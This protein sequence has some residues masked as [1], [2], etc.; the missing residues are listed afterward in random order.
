MSQDENDRVLNGTLPTDPFADLEPVGGSDDDA[1]PEN[2]TEYSVD[3]DGGLVWWKPT[4]DGAVPVKLA[5]FSAT[6][7]AEVVEDD[8]AEER[9]S[10]DLAANVRGRRR[11][12]RV[13]GSQFA[14]MAWVVEEL[15][16]GAILEPGPGVKDRVRHAVQAL[17]GTV[18][19]RRVFTHLGWRELEEGR[20]GFLHNGGAITADGLDASVEVDLDEAL[21]GF[22]LPEPPEGEELRR[23]V[24]ASLG[25]LHVAPPEAAYPLLAATYRA[26]LGRCDFGIW[27]WGRTGERKSELA[28]LVQ[29]H[30]GAGMD[31]QR[32][33]EAW[34]S[35][36]NALELRA[37]LSSDVVLVV[38][39]FQLAEDESHNRAM[40]RAAE[41]L[42]RAS[43]N[44]SGRGRMTR[45]QR[46]RP[47]RPPRGLVLSTAE[48]LPRGHS[49]NARLFVVEVPPG[50][51]D[52][53]RL[54]TA[55]A[56]AAAGR[57]AQ[58]MSAFLRW[59]AP[60]IH[61]ARSKVGA[62]VEELRGEL[63]RDGWHGRTADQVANLLL[64]LRAFARFAREVDAISE[65]ESAVLLETGRNVLLRIA[66]DQ[67]GLQEQADPVRR[68]LEL[69][70]SAITSGRAHV[71]STAGKVPEGAEGWG[72]RLAGEGDDREWS[73]EAERHGEVWRAQGR[74]IG[75]LDGEDLYLDR[76]AAAG[77][78][79]EVARSLG[80]ALAMRPA[81]LVKRLGER[82]LL[83]STDLEGARRTYTVRK[84]GLEGKRRD[85]LHL[86]ASTFGDDGE[87]P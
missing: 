87:A 49:L 23:A 11:T 21:S 50:G 1:D 47:G 8:G 3:P 18:P 7:A 81:T 85:V 29:R 83:R 20:W 82:G 12:V 75:W 5:N 72:W 79:A 43:G 64:G 33:P 25:L 16:A 38:D 53:E 76:D 24:R 28:A 68:F 70:S 62:R 10:F 40:Y 27:L 86:A 71:A 54:T 69:V 42:I 77:A 65:D 57:Y 51:V 4:N 19:T 66:S 63:H 55:Q 45:D 48:E 17:S 14:S 39:D 32:L 37:F 34:S 73:P 67:V 60:K 84:R 78:A 52:L 61:E 74:R 36:P 30:Y 2:G 56:D 13:P 80:E 26:P 44:A 22:E 46:L 41:R 6:I 58:S 15:G 9:R 59:L 35:T 31:R